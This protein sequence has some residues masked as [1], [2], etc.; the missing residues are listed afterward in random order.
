MCTALKLRLLTLAGVTPILLMASRTIAAAYAYDGASRLTSVV[1][2]TTSVSYA[3][4]GEG[5]LVRRC[6][7]G[8][9]VNVVS[10][11][12]SV[13]GD[14]FGY[15]AAHGPKGIAATTSSGS[16]AL[17]L[18]DNV[19]TV[20]GTVG[21]SGA[22]ASRAAFDSYGSPRAILGSPVDAGFTGEYSSPKEQSVW[23]RARS[24]ARNIGRFVQH[25]SFAGEAARPSSLNR[26][27]Y[28]ENNPVNATDPTG[29]SPE[30]EYRRFS[31]D[32]PPPSFFETSDFDGNM[33]HGGHYWRNN[34]GIKNDL[35]LPGY[36]EWV[37]ARDLVRDRQLTGM[38]CG[39]LL[40]CNSWGNAQIASILDRDTLYTGFHGEVVYADGQLVGPNGATPRAI[41]YRNAE[42]LFS[43]ISKNGAKWPTLLRR[44]REV[45]ASRGQDGGFVNLGPAGWQVLGGVAE[46]AGAYGA[47]VSA[48]RRQKECP[49]DSWGQIAPLAEFLVPPLLASLGA[50]GPAIG[51]GI[52]SVAVHNSPPPPLSFPRTNGGTARTG[53]ERRK[54]GEPAA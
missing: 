3:Y 19:G 46:A 33:I 30:L 51:F 39:L 24:Y 43:D 27:A 40:V 53:S 32:A 45:Q 10:D 11:G 37:D 35:R 5:A 49:G 14:T 17:P 44:L 41:T 23:L 12:K 47:V 8:T 38:R 31:L 6:T 15:V 28:T 13:L 9:C 54:G 26:Y 2:G 50:P 42:P 16:S 36:D 4:D 48:V 21:A 18:E 20:R 22:V 52:A 29:H 25:D 7:N 1:D 34:G